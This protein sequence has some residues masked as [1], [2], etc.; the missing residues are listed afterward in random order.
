MAAIYVSFFFK[1]CKMMSVLIF[2]SQFLFNLYF[3]LSSFLPQPQG[4]GAKVLM[5]RS[6]QICSSVYFWFFSCL[7]VPLGLYGDTVDISTLISIVY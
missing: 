3:E 2:I 7:F 6:L 4:L 1:W 5:L